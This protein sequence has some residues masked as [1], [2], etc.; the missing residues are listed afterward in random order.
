MSINNS[1]P[2]SNSP[3]HNAPSSFESEV[4]FTYN[5]RNHT[6]TFNLLKLFAHRSPDQTTHTSPTPLLGPLLTKTWR[7][8][9]SVGGK[10]GG[11]APTTKLCLSSTPREVQRLTLQLPPV[12]LQGARS[13]HRS[14]G[15]LEWDFRNPLHARPSKKA[16][17]G[18]KNPHDFYISRPL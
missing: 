9:S 13:N 14:S 16:V 5:L 7:I 10:S 4:H 17:P 15:T 2:D 3:D 18:L 1:T 11:G 12:R 6:C 8:L